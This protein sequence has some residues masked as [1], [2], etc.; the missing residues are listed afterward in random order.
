MTEIRDGNSPIRDGNSRSWLFSHNAGHACRNGRF[1][2][3]EFARL[4]SRQKRQQKSD[5]FKNST[6]DAHPLRLLLT[7]LGE[8]RPSRGNSLPSLV[9]GV[10]AEAHLRCAPGSIQIQ[11]KRCI[12]LKKSVKMDGQV[13][14][15]PQYAER[16]IVRKQPGQQAPQLPKRGACCAG[17]RDRI[18]RSAALLKH[19]S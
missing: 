17:S 16:V 6:A 12:A 2:T 5:N 4:V 15:F 11:V 14:Q 18:A 13:L 9:K 1:L 7:V 8:L 10:R 3:S 19:R